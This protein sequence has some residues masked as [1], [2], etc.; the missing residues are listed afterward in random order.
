MKSGNGKIWL[1]V[2]S[3]LRKLQNA[4]HWVTSLDPYKQEIQIAI[5]AL[6]EA[7]KKIEEEK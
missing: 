7:K 4:N 5:S 3:A 2:D 6:K 1:A